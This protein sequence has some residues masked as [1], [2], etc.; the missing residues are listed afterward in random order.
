MR[1][2]STVETAP[3]VPRSTDS[4]KFDL[5]LDACSTSQGHVAGRHVICL[6]G[7]FEGVN[8]LKME[9]GALS[10]TGLKNSPRKCPDSI[11]GQSS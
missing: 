10:W 6:I 3:N 9:D 5:M 2:G 7:I 8:V 11:A 4:T 1:F